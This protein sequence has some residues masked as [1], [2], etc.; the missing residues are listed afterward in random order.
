MSNLIKIFRTV[1]LEIYL[2]SGGEVVEDL[3]S[4]PNV[5]IMNVAAGDFSNPLARALNH[6]CMQL[7]VLYYFMRVSTKCNIF[8]LFLGEVLITPLLASKMLSKKF[9]LMFGITPSKEHFVN[10]DIF[11]KLWLLFSAINV[12]FSNKLIVY[13]DKIIQGAN[14][15]KYKSKTILA[16]EHSVDFAKFYIEHILNERQCIIGYVG[17]FSEVKGVLNFVQ[18]IPLLLKEKATTFL[19]AGAGEL[20][21]ELYNYIRVNKLE[22]KVT[23]AGWVPHDDLRRTLNKFKLLVLPSYSEALPNVLLEAMACGTPVLATPVGAIPDI[24]NDGETGFLL[25]SNDPKHIA[26]RIVEL[27][28]KPEL[29]E[30]V[31]KNANEWVR[32]NFSYEKTVEAWRKVLSEL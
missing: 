18:A 5:H 3:V 19:I 12:K 1:G 15:E 6:L 25:K 26:E 11:S 17:R 10:E 4:E 22:T 8:M 27:L 31:S 20:N 32:E 23:L 29:L 24:I 14:L 21:S 30:K 16:H 2:I 7:R 28:N 13:S 9:I